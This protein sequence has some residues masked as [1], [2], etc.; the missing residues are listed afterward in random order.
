MAVAV[1]RG[2]E[3]RWRR[4]CVEEGSGGIGAHRDGAATA[5]AAFGEEEGSGVSCYRAQSGW[6]ERRL[7]L[8]SEQRKGA[9][10][11]AVAALDCIT[12]ALGRILTHH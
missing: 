12:A 3:R 6:R 10:S 11:A 9:A 8:R 4:R 5:V 1:C 7:L 2:R